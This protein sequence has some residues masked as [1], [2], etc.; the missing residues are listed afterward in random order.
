MATKQETTQET[1]QE[2]FPIY[3]VTLSHMGAK[4]A[5]SIKAL[6]EGPLL[7]ELIV[8]QYMSK[9]IGTYDLFDHPVIAKMTELKS[10]FELVKIVY[11][12]ITNVTVEGN[13]DGDT[14]IIRFTAFVTF[15]DISP[16]ITLKKCDLSVKET[17]INLE[18]RTKAVEKQLPDIEKILNYEEKISN[19]ESRISAI[20]KRALQDE[21]HLVKT[22]SISLNNKNA[23]TEDM[24]WKGL[25]SG[26]VTFDNYT[27]SGG[28]PY[29]ERF[30]HDHPNV[31]KYKNVGAVYL[32]TVREVYV[33]YNHVT[34]RAFMIVRYPQYVILYGLIYLRNADEIKFYVKELHG[35]YGKLNISDDEANNGLLMIK[36]GNIIISK[37]SKVTVNSNSLAYMGEVNDGFNVLDFDEKLEK[38]TK[39]ET[40]KNGCEIW[41]DDSLKPSPLK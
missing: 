17:L 38:D 35:F 2:E 30:K 14:M 34:F 3:R 18:S 37:H 10:R 16:E 40:L 25:N 6:E 28:L 29:V 24:L 39:K 27:K 22:Y 33:L 8:D 9:F 36:N 20:E 41:Y 26:S 23:Y 12:K 31:K 13:I 32:N 21:V 5:I 7:M 11:D 1:K 4:L 19:L 15:D